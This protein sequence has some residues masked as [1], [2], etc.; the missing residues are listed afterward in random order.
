MLCIKFDCLGADIESHIT[1]GNRLDGVDGLGGYVVLDLHR[2]HIIDRQKERH[3]PLVRFMEQLICQFELIV[4]NQRLA[5]FSSLRFLEG[6]GHSPAD[7]QSIHFAHQ[8]AD[9]ADLV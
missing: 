4:L 2:D 9:D 5:D 3:S 6:I 7:E 8:I 1:L